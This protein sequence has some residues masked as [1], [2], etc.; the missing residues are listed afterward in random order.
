MSNT[1]RQG[2]KETISTKW[3]E[4]KEIIRHEYD[5]NDISYNTWV[6]TLA[7]HDVDEASG[8]VTILILSDN[9]HTLKY[10]SSKYTLFFKVILTEVLGIDCDVTFILDKKDN[11]TNNNSE[12]DKTPRSSNYD[13]SNLN[14]KYTFDTFVV[15]SNNRFAHSVA[16]AVAENPGVEYNPLYLY[17]SAGL[18]KTHLI[19]AIGDFILKNNP[20]MKVQYVSSEHFTNEVI[21]AIRSGNTA[22][23][24]KIREK[25]RTVDVLLLDD[26]QFIIGK[27][28]TQEEF[29]HTFNDLHSAGKHI[30]L[31]SDKPPKHMETLEERLRNRFGWGLIADMQPPDYETRMAILQK[32]ATLQNKKIDDKI[33]EYIATNVTSNVRELEGALNK[34]LAYTRIE[35]QELNISDVEYALKDIIDNKKHEVTPKLIINIVAE[36]YNVSPENII[37]KK[38]NSEFAQP[39]QIVMYLCRLL[40][41]YSYTQIATILGKKDHSTIIYGERKISNDILTDDDLKTRIDNI[42]KII[43]S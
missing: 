27:E 35:K 3:E 33:L 30:I 11:I 2:L 25:Y 22:R 36:Q 10:I 43:S 20:N 21:G 42:V 41:D 15:G 32:Y 6:K 1:G 31:T 23:M 39:R 18:G 40:T 12:V 19:H 14:S 16:L 28:S 37:S 7:F 29:F 26:V 38:K 5:I 9:I 8:I 24:N 34:I 4:I 17:S 13:N